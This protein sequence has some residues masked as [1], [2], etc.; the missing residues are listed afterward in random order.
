MLT[1][2]KWLVVGLLLASVLTVWAATTNFGKLKLSETPEITGS[3]AETISNATDGVWATAGR[4]DVTS[5]TPEI[6]GSNDET[7]SNAT[8]AKW[9]FG[10]ATLYTT[11]PVSN[12]DS[13]ATTK[14]FY[15][16]T[17]PIL[18]TLSFAVDSLGVT[19]TTWPAV[20]TWESDV[21]VLRMQVSA[22]TNVGGNT[23]SVIFYSGATR[24][25]VTVASGAATGNNTSDFNF[26][27]AAV[28]SLD[29][30]DGAA[31]TGGLYP[32][33]TIQYTDKSD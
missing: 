22:T 15:V 19:D 11:G 16:D 12:A 30:Q 26:A 31:G 18:K 9:T 33:I 13:V 17:A 7:I 10:S 28:C 5:G 8:D 3:N 1:R 4:I 25:T 27:A 20:V 21:T 23:C 6:T 32:L 2:V 24:D 29:V 14:A